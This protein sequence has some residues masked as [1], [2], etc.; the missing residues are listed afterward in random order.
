MIRTSRYPKGYYT[1]TARATWGMVITL[2]IF[3]P[4]S[5]P[6]PP[7]C[8]WTTCILLLWSPSNELASLTLYYSCV[9]AYVRARN[10]S[11][12]A[13]LAPARAVVFAAIILSQQIA[14]TIVVGGGLIL[15]GGQ[16]GG[17]CGGLDLHTRLFG[18]GQVQ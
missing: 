15:L 10:A 14:S 17:G 1:G 13:L 9:F 16:W 4:Y 3:L 18:A 11:I 7:E 8:C 12:I 6:Y 2:A 5:N